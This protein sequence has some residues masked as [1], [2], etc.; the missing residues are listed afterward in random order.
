MDHSSTTARRHDIDALRVLAF[1]L[2]IL[3]HVGMY[4]V[5]WGWHVKSLYPAPWL[6][7][8]MRLLNQWRMPLIFLISGMALHFLVRRF[9]PG[10]LM[11][12]RCRRL[13]IPLIF[14]MLVI[15][16]PQAYVEALSNQVF[17]GSYAEFLWAY[18]GGR[19]WPEDAFAGSDNGVT[20][21]HLWYLPYLLLY[22][23]VALPLARW[24]A[25]S[26][27]AFRR[28]L[29]SLRGLSLIALP[30]LPLMAAGLWVFPHFPY[31]SHDLIGDPYA[32]AMYGSFFL[33]GLI[34]GGDPDLAGY[35][36]RQ[37][38]RLLL[39]SALSFTLLEASWRWLADDAPRSHEIAQIVLIYANRW[40]WLLMILGWG[41]RWLNRPLPGLRYANEAVVSWYLLH[42]SIT[43]VV[44]YG[45][46]QWQL[47][48]LLDPLVLLAATIGGCALIHE[49]LVRRSHLL[50]GCFG[51]APQ[52]LPVDRGALETS[53][54]RRTG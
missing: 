40:L 9:A 17:A 11:T 26:G 2:L 31:I 34:I 45:L 50:R 24:M 22:T 37:R 29:L 1:A 12:S 52:R 16:P 32:H 6:E 39:G 8:L 38:W 4:Y 36:A 10:E 23:A 13:L 30:L 46:I 47:G 53:V 28:R 19:P 49:G 33:Y 15:V 51:L 41:H 14:G 42:Q 7:P 20:W 18:F 54:A 48:P 35:L 21:N 43:V 5:S 25:G 27:A 3:Y 44:G